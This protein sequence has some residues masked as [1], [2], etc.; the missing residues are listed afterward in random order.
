[1]NDFVYNNIPNICNYI[2][3]IYILWYNN[4]DNNNNDKRM[5]PGL[6][7]SQ[8]IGFTSMFLFFYVYIFV[9]VNVRTTSQQNNILY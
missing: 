8:T 6:N 3:N 7:V 4:N 9:F 1:M 2:G 5:Y